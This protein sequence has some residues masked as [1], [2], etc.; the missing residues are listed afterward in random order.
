MKI[1]SS[2]LYRDIIKRA[3][4]ITWHNRFLWIFGFFATFLGLGGMYNFVLKSGWQTNLLYNQIANKITTISVSGVL[5]TGNLGKINIL[6]LFLL[7]LAIVV[8][9]ILAAFF[10]WLAVNS[11]GALIGGAQVFDKKRKVG[12]VKSFNKS[13]IYFWPLLGVNLLGKVLIFLFLA[14]TGGILSLILIDNSAV[15]ALIYF[16][17][18]L[19]FVALSLL[20]SFLIIYASCFLVLKSKK[21]LDS[22]HEAWKLFKRNWVVSIEAAIVLFFINL[23]VSIGLAIILVLLSIPFM[24]LLLIFY[25]ASAAAMPSIILALWAAVA[26]ALMILVGSF[27]SAFQIVAWTLLFDK[28]SKG[29]ILSKLYRIFR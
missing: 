1:D 10:I 29:N 3:L 19:L 24:V 2:S 15:N 23:I 11:F 21:T 12:L 18:S 9:G 5:I 8:V 26:I 4:L 7:F 20:I 6:N 14:L 28:I 16:L 17:T 25:S 27:F 13:K 22:I